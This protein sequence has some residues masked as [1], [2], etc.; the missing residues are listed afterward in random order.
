MA[1]SGRFVASLRELQ[2]SFAAAL[3][4]PAVDCA[5]LPPANLSVYRN[6]AAL[7]FRKT[8]QLGFPVVERRVG[9][10]YF[11]QLAALYRER[12]PSRSGDLHWVGRD[13][14]VFLDDY[15]AGSDYAWLA[16]LARLEWAYQECSVAIEMAPLGPEALAGFAATDLEHVVFG[17]QP[18]LRLLASPY[19]VYSVWRANQADN[20]PPVD[21]SLGAE[22]GMTRQREESVEV[23]KLEPR[24]FSFVSSLRSGAT[25]GDAMTRAELDA[26]ALTQALAFVFSEGLVVSVAP[27]TPLDEQRVGTSS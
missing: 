5:V 27:R 24:L 7:T 15:L 25:L 11:R 13:F 17:F 4:D 8:L 22:C 12:F 23:R 14:A 21:Q 16:D 1:S 19:P 3:R 26:G 2:Q 18:S 20:A 9:E 6:N 10:D